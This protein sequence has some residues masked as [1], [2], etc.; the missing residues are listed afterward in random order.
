MIAAGI[1][2]G[3]GFGVALGLVFDNLALGIAIGTAI[4]VALGAAMEQNR[5][6]GAADAYGTR[7]RPLWIVVTVGLLL[8]GVALA[9]FVVLTLT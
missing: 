1:P 7:R 3:A 5:G 4:G 2:V 9:T 6:R 8:L